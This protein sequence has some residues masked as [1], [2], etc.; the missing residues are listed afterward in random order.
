MYTC[1]LLQIILQYYTVSQDSCSFYIAKGL[2]AAP[3]VLVNGVLLDLEEEVSVY[4]C[5]ILTEIT[6]HTRVHVE[7]TCMPL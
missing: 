4:T 3:Q 1:T 5:N 7:L 6:L 2:P